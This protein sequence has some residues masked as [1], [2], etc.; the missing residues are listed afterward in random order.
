MSGGRPLHRALS[1]ALIGLSLAAVLVV[2]ATSYAVARQLLGDAVARQLENHQGAQVRAL[3][4]GLD[5]VEGVVSTIAADS[6]MAVATR[7]LGEAFRAAPADVRNR[8]LTDPAA[9]DA[10]ARVHDARD[11]GLAALQRTL[12]AGDE[13][14]L[15]DD[16]GNVVYATGDG[17]GTEAGVGDALLEA[18]AQRLEQST[19]GETV[20][21]DIIASSGTDEPPAMVAAASVRDGAEVVGAVALEIPVPTIN[22]LTTSVQGWEGTGLGATGETYVVGADRLLRSDARPYLED[23]TAYLDALAQAGAPTE[24]VAAIDRAGTTVLQQSTDGEGVERALDGRRFAGRSENYLGE[25]T[26]TV[27]GP[28]GVDSLD[29]VVVSDIATSQARAALTDLEFAVLLAALVLV[30]TVAVGGLLLARRIARQLRPVLDGAAAIADG[31]LDAPVPDLGRTEVGDVG[32]QLNL[33]AADLRDRRAARESQEAQIA[34]LLG[35][36]LPQRVVERLRAT[37]GRVADVADT[38]TVVAVTVQ[39]MLPAGDVASDEAADLGARLSRELEAA[40]HRSG[41]ERV[42]S[43]S[44]HH[45]F[46]AGLGAADPAAD[47]AAGFALELD[48]VL[49]ELARSAGADVTWRVGMAAGDVVAGLLDRDSFTYGVFGRPVHVA[50]ALDAIAVDGQ[51][52]LDRSAASALGSEW[53]L[54]PVPELRDLRGEPVDAMRL[55][56]RHGDAG[57]LEVTG[58]SPELGDAPSGHRP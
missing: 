39:G 45:L 16:R 13:L 23:P 29:W 15:F 52:L 55:A 48:G 19:V 25:P 8:L 40:A 41:L 42:R 5:R 28:L 9:D 38:A 44:E 47:A 50:L 35:A 31:D 6:A 54:E 37:D 10:Y 43:A 18:A 32:R 1:L 7:E 14:L 24:L 33:L 51:I 53:A 4:A 21:T 22:R 26:L 58:M 20:L 11:P 12:A 30:P 27:A 49:A 3:R 36:V 56:G 57:D 46:A 2:G 34:R 17:D